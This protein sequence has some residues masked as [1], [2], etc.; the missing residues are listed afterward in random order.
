[1]RADL[2]IYPIRGL[3]PARQFLASCKEQV[4]LTNIEGSTRYYGM[5]VLD[6][7]FRTLKT[8]FPDKVA[9]I[10]VNIGDDH[11][12][13]YSAIKIGYTRFI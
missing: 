10:I 3:A 5:M 7:M 13:R 9:G 6:Y 11:A 1:M 2:T 12:A 8:E 4:I